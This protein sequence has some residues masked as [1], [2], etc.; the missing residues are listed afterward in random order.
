MTGK[1][2]RLDAEYAIVLDT[3]F[4]FVFKLDTA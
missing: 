1:A 4:F 3:S 2:G